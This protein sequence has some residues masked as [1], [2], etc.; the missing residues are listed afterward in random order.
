M[1]SRK[2]LFL[3]LKFYKIQKWMHSPVIPDIQRLRWEIKVQGQLE[4]LQGQPELYSETLFQKTKHRNN[5]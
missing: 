2:T 1:K 3:S 4:L 5:C